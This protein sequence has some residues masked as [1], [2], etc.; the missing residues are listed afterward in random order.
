MNEIGIDISTQVSKSLEALQER[1]MDVAVILC[2]DRVCPVYPWA[3]EVVHAYFPN[4]GEFTGDELQIQ[5]QF[6]SL[7]DEITSW[8]DR[9]FGPNAGG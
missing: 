5:A 8:I 7:R 3:K 6:R 2:D 4:P 1:E 9:Y